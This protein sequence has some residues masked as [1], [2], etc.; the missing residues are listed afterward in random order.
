VDYLYSPSMDE[1]GIAN[2]MWGLFRSYDP[3]KTANKL[4]PLPNNSVGAG[5]NVTYATCPAVLPP[6]AVKR[7]FNVTA[8]DA[9]KAL[10]AQPNVS[11]L[12]FNRGYPLNG[13]V[14]F[15]SGSTALTGV[16]TSFKTD[17]SVGDLLVLN[18]SSGTVRGR[19]GAIVDNTHITLAANASATA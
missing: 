9:G 14:T 16:G 3:T 6:P 12:I 19:V 7:V 2:G 17:V 10:A 13:T 18:S 11:N 8:V 4:A 5:V 1:T 15:T